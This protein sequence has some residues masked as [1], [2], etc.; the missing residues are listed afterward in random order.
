MTAPEEN[1][2]IAC[3]ARW[4]LHYSTRSPR[5][6][7]ATPAFY[8][9]LD[10]RCLPNS[11]SIH[12]V[13]LTDAFNTP[14]EGLLR[15][16]KH[17]RHAPGTRAVVLAYALGDDDDLYTDAVHKPSRFLVYTYTPASADTQGL[18]ERRLVSVSDGDVR[19]DQDRHLA[20]DSRKPPAVHSS[21]RR[22]ATATATEP[23]IV[24][25]A[26]PLVLH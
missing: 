15:R 24:A 11:E 12:F 2:L 6:L 13:A 16:A 22:A 19:I 5:P 3:A 10:T 8:F 9:T 1:T 18:L 4:A 7:F 20:F 26:A 14:P 17:L 25:P 23:E 21:G